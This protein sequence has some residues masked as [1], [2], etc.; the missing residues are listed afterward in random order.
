MSERT[1]RVA[2]TAWVA[3]ALLHRGHPDRSDFAVAEIVD[4]AQSEEALGPAR[5]R[6]GVRTHVSQHCVA[7]K[8]PD[9]G[10]YRMLFETRAGRRRL[11]REGDPVHPGRRKGKVLPSVDDLPVK[12]RSLIDWYRSEYAAGSAKLESEDSILA[13]RGLGKEIWVAENP[14]E[15][16]RKLRGGWA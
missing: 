11:Y 7:N 2:D 6:P 5:F 15:Y 1:V 9:P 8:K 4:R 3:V 12:Y 10:R 14:D 16:V 13:L